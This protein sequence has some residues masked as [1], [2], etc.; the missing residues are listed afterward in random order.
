[1][2]DL[3]SISFFNLKTQ[4]Y[5]LSIVHLKNVPK[6]IYRL[7]IE[8]YYWVPS[9]HL[10]MPIV[11]DEATSEAVLAGHTVTLLL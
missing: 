8:K 6:S 9:F 11:L 4:N 3:T 7:N 1:M 5:Q 2:Q 10:N